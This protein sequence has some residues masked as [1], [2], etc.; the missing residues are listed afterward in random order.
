MLSRSAVK[1]QALN[2]STMWV[3]VALSLLGMVTA[4]YFYL[5][6]TLGRFRSH[7]MHRDMKMVCYQTRGGHSILQIN[8]LELVKKVFI[9]DS[10]CFVDSKHKA[11]EDMCKRQVMLAAKLDAS[12]EMKHIDSTKFTSDTLHRMSRDQIH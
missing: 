6:R 8:D 1:K 10:N 12:K 11:R 7:E 4:V 9:E 5:T 3:N 2:L